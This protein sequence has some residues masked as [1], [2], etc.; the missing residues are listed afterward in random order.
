MPLISSELRGVNTREMVTLQRGQMNSDLLD[1]LNPRWN[2]EGEYLGDMKLDP[3]MMLGYNEQGQAVMAGKGATLAGATVNGDSVSLRINRAEDTDYARMNVGLEGVGKFTDGVI[4]T[5]IIAGT[6]ALQNPDERLNQMFS[7]MEMYN[8]ENMT[9]EDASDSSLRW[10]FNQKNVADAF[11]Y[12]NIFEDAEGDYEQATRRTVDLAKQ[13]DYT[14]EQAGRIFG[15]L[16]ATTGLSSDELQERYGLDPSWM[17]EIMKGEAVGELPVQFSNPAPMGVGADMSKFS[18]LPAGAY[19]DMMSRTTISDT[20]IA[21]R[22]D[23]L[24]MSLRSL[25]EGAPRDVNVV[26]MEELG[27]AGGYVDAGDAGNVY[28]PPATEPQLRKSY[29]NLVTAGQS[30]DAEQLAA[31]HQDLVADIGASHSE[32]LSTAPTITAG[33]QPMT[34]IPTSTQPSGTVGLSGEQFGELLEGMKGSPDYS[35][36][37]LAMMQ[38]QFDE[39]ESVPGFIMPDTDSAKAQPIKI[40]RVPDLNDIGVAAVPPDMPV[41]EEPTVAVSHPRYES[42]NPGVSDGISVDRPSQIQSLATGA[43][44]LRP[45][46]VADYLSVAGDQQ[47]RAVSKE[48]LAMSNDMGGGVPSQPLGMNFADSISIATAQSAPQ[49]NLAGRDVPMARADMQG[50]RM[51]T[52]TPESVHQDSQAIGQPT[53]P[54]IL[55]PEAPKIDTSSDYMSA[56][57]NVRGRSRSE[58]NPDQ[59]SQN[60]QQVLGNRSRVNT[61]VYDNRSS[62]TSQ[63]IADILSR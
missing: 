21:A 33:A 38:Q 36:E 26:P 41:G 58:L 55:T 50:G 6:S 51:S 32:M 47:A 53:A 56:M 9:E 59:I 63:R 3:N 25:T 15:A 29:K 12:E 19:Q 40:N 27:D 35:D 1:A 5:D 8:R 62:L 30:G 13:M 17:D 34:P 4:D 24:A 18:S 10:L 37:T 14:D 28:I 52:A 16:P 42:G 20:G 43:G 46:E 11:R 7:A 57:I 44:R 61:R 23:Q 22:A 31:A 45:E 2:R 49:S 60:L 54:N 48:T 39:G